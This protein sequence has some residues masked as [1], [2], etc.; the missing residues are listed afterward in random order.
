MIQ[1]SVVTQ[2]H[3]PENFVLL[4]KSEEV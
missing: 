1:I 2:L 3:F 4:I